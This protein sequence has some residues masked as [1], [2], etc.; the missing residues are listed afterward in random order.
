H[1][2]V[3]YN[4]EGVLPA[5]ELRRILAAASA[6][7]RVRR[8]SRRY[9]RYRADSDRDGRRYRGDHVRELLYYARLR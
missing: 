3:S 7:G 4:S 2:L 6:D 8:F 1:V 9:R 5:T